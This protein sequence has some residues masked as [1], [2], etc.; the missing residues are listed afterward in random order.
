M[1]TF[2]DVDIETSA[3][4]EFEVYCNTC[5]AGLCGESEATIGRTRHHLQVRVNACPNCIAEKDREIEDLK[6]EIKYLEE[7]IYKLENQ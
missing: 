2:Y 1:P 5:G 4:I 7:Q 3:D 6:S